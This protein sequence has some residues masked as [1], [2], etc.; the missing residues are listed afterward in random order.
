MSGTN[1]SVL[2]EDRNISNPSLVW[3][4]QTTNITSS[5]SQL[6]YLQQFSLDLAGTERGK[7]ILALDLPCVGPQRKH[8]VND[9][10]WALAQS[11]HYQ[12]EWALCFRRIKNP[13]EEHQPLFGMVKLRVWPI[14]A[15]ERDKA[16]VGPGVET[17]LD[18]ELLDGK[19][20]VVPLMD[21]VVRRSVPRMLNAY[22]YTGTSDTFGRILQRERHLVTRC[23]V[24]LITSSDF[25]STSTNLL[26]PSIVRYEVYLKMVNPSFEGQ[27]S[28]HSGYV[29][30]SGWP[31][32]LDYATANQYP[33]NG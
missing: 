4:P 13:T 26:G 25:R 32:S 18:L 30:F 9:L 3:F 12:G 23:R 7:Q 31:C 29:D 5:A 27:R 11:T 22:Y 19:E 28:G 14:L 16:P 21:Y 24:Q 17:E 1:E 20:F 10:V 33:S 8:A 2:S 6:I 15:F